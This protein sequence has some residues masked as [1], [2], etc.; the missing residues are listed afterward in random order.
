MKGRVRL[1]WSHVK[2]LGRS[3]EIADEGF[4]EVTKEDGDR[5]YLEGEPFTGWL[6]KS[7]INDFIEE[8]P[9]DDIIVPHPNLKLRA[10]PPKI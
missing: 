10:L 4:C 2:L 7:E 6:D 9:G 8:D 1:N 3:L 5:I